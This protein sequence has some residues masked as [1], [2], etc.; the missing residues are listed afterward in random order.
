MKTGSFIATLLFF[1]SVSGF[2]FA[3]QADDREIVEFN[4]SWMYFKGDPADAHLN[5]N[6]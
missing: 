3:L 6:T 4:T 2:I 1:Y 5:T